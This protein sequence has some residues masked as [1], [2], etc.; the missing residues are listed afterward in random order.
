MNIKLEL[1]EA[2]GSGKL[3]ITEFNPLNTLFFHL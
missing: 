1:S 3:T 2:N